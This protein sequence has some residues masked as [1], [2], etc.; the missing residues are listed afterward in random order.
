VVVDSPAAADISWLDG[1]VSVFTAEVS[2]S[3]FGVAVLICVPEVVSLV[4]DLLPL[5]V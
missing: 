3:V 1:D 4:P 2:S 5:D